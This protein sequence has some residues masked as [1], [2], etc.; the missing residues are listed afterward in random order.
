MLGWVWNPKVLTFDVQ[1]KLTN[2]T[3]KSNIFLGSFLDFLQGSRPHRKIPALDS[4]WRGMCFRP[5]AIL[6]LWSILSSCLIFFGADQWEEKWYVLIYRQC[7][8]LE[9]YPSSTSKCQKTTRSPTWT[10]AS[11]KLVVPTDMSML[12]PTFPRCKATSCDKFLPHQ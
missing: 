2:W 1:K 4:T 6:I 12:E 10:Y 11:S 3:N 5:L 8:C 9:R 7:S